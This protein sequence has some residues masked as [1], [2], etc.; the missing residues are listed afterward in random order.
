MLIIF[1]KLVYLNNNEDYIPFYS[2]KPI[3]I[4]LEYHQTDLNKDE[5]QIIENIWSETVQK[6]SQIFRGKFSS[7]FFFF[8]LIL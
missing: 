2:W 3:R 1:S 7:L 5:K 8:F 4:K 6:A